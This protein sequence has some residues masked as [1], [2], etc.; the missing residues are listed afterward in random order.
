MGLGWNTFLAQLHGAALYQLLK[1]SDGRTRW[2]HITSDQL[3]E[4]EFL[5]GTK[6]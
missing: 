4:E 1:S 6:F 2:L 3:A 5:S